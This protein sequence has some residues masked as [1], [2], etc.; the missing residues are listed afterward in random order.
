MNKSLLLGPAALLLL[1]ACSAAAPPTS[2]RLVAHASAADAAGTVLVVDVCLNH[3]PL[4]VDD[5]FVISNS[6]QGAEALM[7]ATAQYFD[8]SDVRIRT[9]LIP[10]VCGALHDD[11]NGPKRVA[12]AIDADVSVR[13]QPVWISPDIS[14]DAEYVDALHTLSTYVFK[15]SLALASAQ[16]SASAASL[17]AT[18]PDGL[19]KA[20]AVVAQRSGRS[21]L[22]YVGVTGHS[23][24]SGKAATLGV[25]RFAAGLA[26][27]VAIGPVFAA[28]GMNYHVVILP[29]GPVDKRQ[30]VAALFDLRQ[31]ALVRSNVIH[32]FGDPMKAEVLAS[33]ESVQLLLRDVA[34]SNTG[35]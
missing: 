12:E 14:A 9:K 10:F 27:S 1:A 16:A 34:F 21:S 26:L 19:H 32:G 15:R 2:R 11:A 31:A 18:V 29:G 22:I 17:D 20:A 6:K 33:R 3:S 8:A 5:Y 7:A 23:L 25:A 30:M 24:S 13:P 28:G 35:K 4:V